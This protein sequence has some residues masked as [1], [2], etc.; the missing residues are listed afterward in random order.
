[1]VDLDLPALLAG[2][3][4]DGGDEDPID[5]PLSCRGI[6]RPVVEQNA[7]VD[8]VDSRQAVVSDAAYRGRPDALG[9]SRAAGA[10]VQATHPAVVA[11]ERNE[12]VRGDDGMAEVAFDMEPPAFAPVREVERPQRLVVLA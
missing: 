6:D 5:R 3:Q 10:T 9:P 2:L 4:V 12:A 7:S 11:A 8:P 1:M